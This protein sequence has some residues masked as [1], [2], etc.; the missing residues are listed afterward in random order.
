MRSSK[1]TVMLGFLLFCVI[2][3]GCMSKSAQAKS[4]PVLF[5]DTQKIKAGDSFRIPV[6][7]SGNPGMMGFMVNVS[8]DEKNLVIDAVESGEITGNGLFDHNLGQKAGTF[9]I[10]WSHTENM[11]EDGTVFYLK[12]KVAKQAAESI[13]ISLGYSQPD[14]FNEEYQDVKLNCKDI[15]LQITGNKNA[16]AKLPENKNNENNNDAN[17]QENT[18]NGKDVNT[19]LPVNT[20]EG[21]QADASDTQKSARQNVQN[22]SKHVQG[23]Q[24]DNS[25]KT[26]EAIN[27][28]LDK[29]QQKDFSSADT[30]TRQKMVA[31]AKE[32]LKELGVISEE[33]EELGEQADMDTQS[34]FL[35]QIYQKAQENLSEKNSM[36]PDVKTIGK[37]IVVFGIFMVTVLF[38]WKKKR[39]SREFNT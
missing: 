10:L 19:K 2:V 23:L 30:E 36:I 32:E 11:T 17:Q 26:V 12:G 13:V 25:R 8:F 27:K 7:I 16:D 22:S 28:I 33:T 20:E 1:K 31:E 38:L 4:N 29:Y 35:D 14:T 18:D 37:L 5:A 34:A 39:E 6:K 15:Q 9:E 21:N 24:Q 3:A